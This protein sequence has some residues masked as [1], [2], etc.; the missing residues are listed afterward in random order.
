MTAAPR[1][2]KTGDN[3]TACLLCAGICPSGAISF[4]DPRLAD[5]LVCISCCA[6]VKACPQ[7][8]KYFDDE[9]LLQ[10]KALAE[11]K[12][13]VRREPELFC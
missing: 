1:S 7:E 4:D 13:L 8:A 3:C 10:R 11:S 9:S 6:C 12:F 2:P 5:S